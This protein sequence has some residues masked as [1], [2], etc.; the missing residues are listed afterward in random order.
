MEVKVYSMEIW[1]FLDSATVQKVIYVEFSNLSYPSLNYVA[2]KITVT[3]GDVASFLD[4]FLYF[5]T[6]FGDQDV[7]LN[8]LVA[9]KSHFCLIIGVSTL[10]CMYTNL[11]R[12]T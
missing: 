5:H 1:D 10:S 2:K 6:T 7:R 4:S 8:F 12:G 9:E 11:N 3:N